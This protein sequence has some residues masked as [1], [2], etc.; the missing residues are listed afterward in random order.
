MNYVKNL[1]PIAVAAFVC[2]NAIGAGLV[3]GS[4]AMGKLLNHSST[5]V[6]VE[7]KTEEKK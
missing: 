4:W 5:V 6:T 1:A 2:G 3:L 7:D